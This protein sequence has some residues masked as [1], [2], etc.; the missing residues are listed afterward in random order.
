[1]NLRDLGGLATDAG[2]RTRSGVLLRSAGPLADDRPPAL[3]GWPP[4]LVLDLRGIDELRGRPHPLIAEGSVVHSLPLLRRRLTDAKGRVDWSTVPDLGSAYLDFMA[5]GGSTIVRI[6]ELLVDSPGPAL[7]HCTAGKDRTGV[8]VAV[9][10]RAVGVSRAELLRDYRATEPA[11]PAILARTPPELTRDVD[12]T[13]LERLMGVPAQAMITVLDAL[14]N[15]DGGAAGWLTSRGVTG[16][17]LDAWR[18]RIL[19]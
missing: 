6:A 14:D 5:V 12:P 9:L 3:P 19:E 16:P 2:G 18:R 11:L 7:V 8:V 4:A 15:S 13:A 17:V 1:P 10:L